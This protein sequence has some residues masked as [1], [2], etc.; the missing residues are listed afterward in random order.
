MVLSLS[1]LRG[2]AKKNLASSPSLYERAVDINHQ[3]AEWELDEGQGI[4][5][6]QSFS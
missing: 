5:M 4:S 1:E 3:N 6:F 2:G